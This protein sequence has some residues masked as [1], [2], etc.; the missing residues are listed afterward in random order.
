MCHQMEQWNPDWRQRIVFY[1]DNAMYHKSEYLK[2]KAMKHQI[3][4]F[5]SG[6]YSFN[7]AP[8]EKLFADIKRHDLNPLGKNFQSRLACN[9]YIE[10]LAET[11]NKMNFG[12]VR[13]LFRKALAVN[14][15]YLLFENI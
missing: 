2:S 10:W 14:E 1:L 3:P 12:N 7:A 4:L 8:C 13:G 5:F 9:T 15:K 6:P 11:I